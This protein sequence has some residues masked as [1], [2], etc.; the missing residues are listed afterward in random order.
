MARPTRRYH[1]PSALRLSPARIDP[2]QARALLERGAALIDVRRHDDPAL[3]LE[4][5]LRIPPDEIPAR[6]GELP[7]NLPIVLAC[8]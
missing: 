7:R 6:L 3:V 8:T 1:L 2:G 4:G 5:A